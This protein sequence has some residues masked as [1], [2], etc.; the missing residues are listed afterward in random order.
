M[1]KQTGLFKFTG[2]LDNVIGYR[3]N[4]SHFVRSMPDKIK[5]T[6]ATRRA[7][8][9]FGVASTKGKLIRR[10]VT[11][12]LT[13]YDGT[14]VNRLNRELIR[15][16]HQLS[17]IEGFRFNRHT[18]LDKIFHQPALYADG[19]LKIPAQELPA[20]RRAT[21]LQVCLIAARINFT[22]RRVIEVKALSQVIDL[23]KEFNGMEV[24]L[25]VNGKGTLV[26]TL[27][28]Q[29]CELF[30]GKL[31]PIRD[32]RYMAADIVSVVSPMHWTPALGKTG[33][34]KRPHKSL[35]AMARNSMATAYGATKQSPAIPAKHRS[36]HCEEQHAPNL[37]YEAPSLHE[38][39]EARRPGQRSDLPPLAKDILLPVE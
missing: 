26:L 37:R 13:R 12:Y 4:G 33:K 14:L 6:S 31:L 2:K 20:L 15:A 24:E 38:T 22:E 10:A 27:Q 18:G 25:P 39:A 29:A 35:P 5:Q 7:S 21:H 9:S 34:K 17:T 11:P 23:Q 8:R 32:R 1:A 36:P 28:V 30:N 19:V 16:G 3:R